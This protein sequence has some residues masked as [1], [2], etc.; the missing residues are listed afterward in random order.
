MVVVVAVVVVVMAVVVVVVGGYWWW[1]GIGSGV[2]VVAVRVTAFV[3][4]AVVRVVE[5]L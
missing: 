2:V 5:A 1:K 3:R 4:V